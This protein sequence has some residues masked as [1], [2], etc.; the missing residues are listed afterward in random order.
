MLALLES[1][2]AL[3]RQN[4]LNF[5][6]ASCFI[7]LLSHFGLIFLIEQGL[8]TGTH[9]VRPS[10]YLSI[11]VAT[12]ASGFSSKAGTEDIIWENFT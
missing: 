5:F 12:A 4:S 9:S 8:M 11:R 1:E 2:V 10:W 7:S 3:I 6:E